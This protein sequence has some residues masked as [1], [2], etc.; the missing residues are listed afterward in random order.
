MICRAQISARSRF[1]RRISLQL[2]RIRPTFLYA[3]IDP[4]QRRLKIGD[5]RVIR[6]VDRARTRDKHIIGSRFSLTQQDRSCRAAQPPLCTVA[7]YRIADL[8]ACGEPH[9][10]RR[11]AP[12]SR[13]PW[14]GLQD[15]TRRNRP[16]AGGSDTQEIGAGLER[17]KPSV[18][19]FPGRLDW[20]GRDQRLKRTDV[21][22]PLRAATPAPCVRL[23]LPCVPET[24][25]GACERGCW[26]GKC[27][28]RH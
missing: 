22:G 2:G 21:C 3:V 5:E 1:G 28:S 11:D 12:R 10:D 8:S 17:Y 27:A 19:R 18:S 13:R 6:P 26:A 24:R 9:P 16:S 23:P 25:G 14:R 20:V 4:A 7:G 15:Q